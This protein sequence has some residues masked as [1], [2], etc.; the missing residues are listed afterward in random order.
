[1]LGHYSEARAYVNR[2]EEAQQHADVFLDFDDDPVS[3]EAIQHDWSGM[4]FSQEE[5]PFVDED[6][7][8]ILIAECNEVHGPMPLADH[9]RRIKYQAKDLV[10]HLLN[11]P[12]LSPELERFLQFATEKE[13][14][15]EVWA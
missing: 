12:R 5:N 7:D 9:A 13:S 3:K 15:H 4:L 11:L 10:R 2:D 1:M 6:N 14:P 8:F